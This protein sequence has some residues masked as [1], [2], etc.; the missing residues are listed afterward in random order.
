M[1]DSLAAPT[2]DRADDLQVGIALASVGFY[3][4]GMGAVLAGLASEFSVAPESLSWVGS[5]FGAGLLVIAATG[6]LVLRAG[7]RPALAASAIALA[8]STVLAVFGPTLVFV[9]I[10]AVLQGLSASVMVLVAPVMLT[11]SAD[12]RLTRVNA[13]SSLVGILAP[14]LVGAA[15]GVGI[16]GRWALLTL[17]PLLIWLLALLFLHARAAG[18]AQP[19]AEPARAAESTP[20][21]P[22]ASKPSVWSVVRRWLAVVMSVSVEFSYV[23]WGVTRL[24]ATGIDTGLA[25]VLGIAFPV[26][27]AVGRSAGPW[28]IRR[29][30]AV[31]FGAG[32][33]ALGTL[34][35]VIGTGWPIVTAGLIIAGLGVATMY[36]VTLA[37]LM[38]VE[39]LAAH[40]GAAVG[41]AASGTAILL[42]PVALAA[43]AAVVDLRLAFLLQLPLLIILLALHGRSGNRAAP[44]K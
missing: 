31:P 41:A 20:A 35:V 7:P 21:A 18:S 33:A 36:P 38:A 23:V 9:F 43:V 22:E 25:S 13:V 11:A 14:L 34:L 12:V 42:A 37:R 1:T 17:V 16:P 32:V 26:G 27:M 2:I 24:I 15:V 8:L 19:V 4:S 10:A 30:P 6:R 28:I 44:V 39:G 5:T 29:L 40:R 3:V